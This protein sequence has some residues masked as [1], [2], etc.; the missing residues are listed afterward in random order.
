MS[1]DQPP[2]GGPHDE[3][4]HEIKRLQSEVEELLAAL[5]KWQK[6]Y[7]ELFGTS[8]SQQSA[9]NALSEE[10]YFVLLKHRASTGGEGE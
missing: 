10:T 3:C 6:I 4:A 8:T 9:I 5:E 2:E 1:F 7:P